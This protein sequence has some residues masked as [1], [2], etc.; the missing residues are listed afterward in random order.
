MFHPLLEFNLVHSSSKLHQILNLLFREKKV[1]LMGK[2]L[3]REMIIEDYG[4][5]DLNIY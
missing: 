2:F 5:S 3:G 4:S 1:K